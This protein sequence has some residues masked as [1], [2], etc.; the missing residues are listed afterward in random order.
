MQKI[1][2]NAPNAL[3]IQEITALLQ[4]LTEKVDKNL[5]DF[6]ATQRINL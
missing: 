1:A 2:Q 6:N 4:V 5:A 3:M